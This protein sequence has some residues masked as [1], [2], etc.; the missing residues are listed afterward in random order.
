MVQLLAQNN[1]VRLFLVHENLHVRE[2]SIYDILSIFVETQ[3]E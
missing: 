1:K 2:A 3:L